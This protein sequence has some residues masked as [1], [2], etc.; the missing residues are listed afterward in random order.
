MAL[1][2]SFMDEDDIPAFGAIDAA[3]MADWGMAQAQ[4]NMITNGKTRRQEVE[5]WTRHGFRNASEQ[6][7]LKVT[8]T[9]TGA[10]ISVAM[11]RFHPDG[12]MPMPPP[13][14]DVTALMAA[15]REME[16]QF[17]GQFIGSKPYASKAR[18]KF[19]PCSA[20]T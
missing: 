13:K 17:K 16:K 3:A 15:K 5:D 7:W 8:D 2:V 9:E 14:V 19:K 12:D 4:Q 18:R 1:Q 6:V 20:T 11:W 10:L